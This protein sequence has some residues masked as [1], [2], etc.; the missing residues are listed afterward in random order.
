MPKRLSASASRTRP[1]PADQQLD[2]FIYHDDLAREVPVLRK[3]TRP[4]RRLPAAKAPLPKKDRKQ[5]GI[6]LVL[7]TTTAL[8]AE[9]GDAAKL[10]G[11][12]IKQTLEA[13]P[14]RIQRVI[15]RL[16]VLQ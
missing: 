4:A 15:L 2:E 12:M 6:E 10:W 8:A 14:P 1:G 9:R 13:P 5:E 7:E 16:C 3:E 11:S